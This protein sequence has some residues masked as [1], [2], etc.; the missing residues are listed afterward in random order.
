MSHSEKAIRA[1]SLDA[2]QN[3]RFYNE[4]KQPILNTGQ[5]RRF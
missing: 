2:R 5:N 3:R 1:F 4:T